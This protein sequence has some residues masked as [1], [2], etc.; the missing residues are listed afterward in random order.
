MFTEIPQLT[1]EEA[2]QF[3]DSNKWMAM[4]SPELALFQMQQERLCVPFNVFT[5]AVNRTVGR[6]ASIK[7]YEEYYTLLAEIKEKANAF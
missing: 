2:L 6:T 4:T 7:E 5:D 3:H 1:I